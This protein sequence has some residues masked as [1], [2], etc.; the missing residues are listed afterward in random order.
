MKLTENELMIIIKEIMLSLKEEELL[1]ENTNETYDF[2]PSIY[3][4]LDEMPLEK[5]FKFINNCTNF[6]K[7]LLSKYNNELNSLNMI[8]EEI[9]DNINILF[10]DI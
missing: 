1:G 2:P 6:S 4:K 5:Y 3:K 9:H 7:I 10:K 8:H